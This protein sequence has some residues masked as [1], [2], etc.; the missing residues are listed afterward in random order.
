MISRFASEE[1][2]GLAAFDTETDADPRQSGGT[3]RRE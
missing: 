3:G 1:S 2:A